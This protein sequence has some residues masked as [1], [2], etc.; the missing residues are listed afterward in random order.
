MIDDLEIPMW[1]ADDLAL[2]EEKRKRNEHWARMRKAREYWMTKHRLIL[3]DDNFW[4]WLKDSCGIV[5]H[6]D[7]AGDLTAGVTIVDEKLY[8]LF[9]LK[10]SQ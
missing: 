6:R 1:S 5:P 2:R 10:F 7:S 4:S 9:L 8:L 3:F